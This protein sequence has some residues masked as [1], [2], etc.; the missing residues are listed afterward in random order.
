VKESRFTIPAL[1]AIVLLLTGIA[2]FFA[3]Q[4]GT[5]EDQAMDKGHFLQRLAELAGPG[6]LR[7]EEM[8]VPRSGAPPSSCLSRAVN[9]GEPFMASLVF[10]PWNDHE[11]ALVGLVRDQGGRLWVLL[12]DP[13]RTGGH[14]EHPK[15]WLQTS[16]CRTFVLPDVI[17][18]WQFCGGE[19]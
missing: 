3:W 1:L 10:R 9:S 6:A 4:P 12:F 19:R 15:P 16:N 18:D 11:I 13:D 17:R 5:D 14:G 7:C 2:L 8:D